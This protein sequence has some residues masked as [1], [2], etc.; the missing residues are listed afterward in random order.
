[1]AN[2]LKRSPFRVVAFECLRTTRSNTGARNL[3]TTIRG[4]LLIAI[5]ASGM[6]VAGAPIASADGLS[7]QTRCTIDRDGTAGS[8][9]NDGTSGTS[10]GLTTASSGGHHIVSDACFVVSRSFCAPGASDP[11]TISETSGI[12]DKLGSALDGDGYQAD[13]VRGPAMVAAPGATAD[14]PRGYYYSH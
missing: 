11:T 3:I 8:F 2:Q 1:M 7:C 13:K 5:A 9:D 14:L 6:A 10:R 4:G 12:T